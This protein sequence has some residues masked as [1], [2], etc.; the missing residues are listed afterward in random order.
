MNVPS[1]N[2]SEAEPEIFYYK[3][4][5]PHLAAITAATNVTPATEE[6]LK[7]I[8]GLLFETN[9]SPQ[10]TF[11]HQDTY[12]DINDNEH[13]L[14]QYSVVLTLYYEKTKQIRNIFMDFSQNEEEGSITLN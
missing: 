11:N 4:N 10:I 8:T 3:N 1:V 6:G 2:L 13:V 7:L 5:P 14:D 12:K 9:P